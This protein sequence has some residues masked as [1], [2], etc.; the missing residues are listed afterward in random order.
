MTIDQRAGLRA[1]HAAAPGPMPARVAVLNTKT[2]SASPDK[3]Q[4]IHMRSC[5]CC[6]RE[7]F[8]ELVP[9]G[10]GE[11]VMQRRKPVRTE[12]H[13]RLHVAHTVGQSIGLSCCL[14]VWWLMDG[15]NFFV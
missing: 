6:C 12:G 13:S 4:V 7:V 15:L 8:A 5:C 14:A 10:K 3:P 2:H 1:R 9:G 11:L